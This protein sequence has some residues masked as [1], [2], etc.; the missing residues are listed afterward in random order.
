MKQKLKL[1]FAL[2]VPLIAAFA[3]FDYYQTL[4]AVGAYDTGPIDYPVVDKALVKNRL[5]QVDT[6]TLES[7]R[8]S[9]L[10]VIKWKKVM[11]KIGSNVI[12]EIVPP[13]DPFIVREHYPYDEVFDSDTQSLYFY[14]SHRPKE[15]GHFHL[16]CCNEEKISHYEPFIVGKKPH[17]VHLL[18]I[19]VH[20]D[21]TPLGFFSTNHWVTP[22]ESWYDYKAV[23]DLFQD[24][25]ITHAYPSWPTNQWINHLLKLFKPQIQDM[26]YERDQKLSTLGPLNQALRN[27]K[28][29]ILAQVP[30]SIEIQMQAI[31]EILQERKNELPK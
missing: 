26:L 11:D 29:D 18:A 19:S 9:G 5:A 10:E 8:T 1:L 28:V 15:H 16:F 21:G 12:S 3:V 14:H 6:K 4:P 31:D 2:A 24:F 7:M 20:P 17:S 30:I 22:L 23:Q 27:K 25:E 13:S